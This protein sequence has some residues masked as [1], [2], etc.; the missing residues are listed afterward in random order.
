[1]TN[2][3][4]HLKP[5]VNRAKI[6]NIVAIKVGAL[7]LTYQTHE[8]YPYLDVENTPKMKVVHNR[9]AS[10]NPSVNYYVPSIKPLR[11]LIPS[12]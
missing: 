10:L 11:S 7:K 8:D 2:R 6:V 3:D 9:R 12:K 5:R 4:L 1:M